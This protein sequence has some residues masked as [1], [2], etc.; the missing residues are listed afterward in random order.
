V[1]VIHES[2]NTLH[3]TN[4]DANGGDTAS[5]EHVEAIAAR[6]LQLITMKVQ[7]PNYGLLV[8]RMPVPA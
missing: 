3:L 2:G 5:P 7:G 1:H 4:S 6:I 8:S